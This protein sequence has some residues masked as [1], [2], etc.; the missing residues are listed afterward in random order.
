MGVVSGGVG[1]EG[2]RLPGPARKWKFLESVLILRESPWPIV[3]AAWAHTFPCA[4]LKGPSSHLE[5]AS[6]A[7]LRE[8]AGRLVH[9]H[10][11]MLLW[12]LGALCCACH[13]VLGLRGPLAG[14]AV[15][16]HEPEVSDI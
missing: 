8:A 13:K 16:L 14:V 11:C 15:I 5:L 9:G 7:V 12:V 4:K 10:M 1:W 6:Q 3:E 2:Q